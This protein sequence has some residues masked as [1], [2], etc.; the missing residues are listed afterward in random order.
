MSVLTWISSYFIFWLLFLDISP[1]YSSFHVGYFSTMAFTIPDESVLES[2]AQADISIVQNIKLNG[3]NRKNHSVNDEEIRSLAGNIQKGKF[4]REF[5]P[6]LTI[7]PIQS[8]ENLASSQPNPYNGQQF[9]LFEQYGFPLSAYVKFYGIDTN[10]YFGT[11]VALTDDY[12]FVGASGF[13]KLHNIYCS[14]SIQSDLVCSL[15]IFQGQ[16]TVYKSIG[17]FSWQLATK[18]DS[19]VNDITSFGCS[20]A[21]DG[22]TL[23]IGSCSFGKYL[24]SLH[25]HKCYKP[26]V[27]FLD[28]YVGRVY[29]YNWFDETN[30]G[31]NSILE[32]P[33]NRKITGFGYSVAVKGTYLV[34]G[35]GSADHGELV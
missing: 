9:P 31:L 4:S 1:S 29:V 16:V 8:M 25:I 20:I 15:D 23:V 19:P 12:A 32:S 24:I 27:S 28:S 2:F 10:G 26:F 6:D 11:S 33:F 7:I 17:P 5:N 30:F 22:N 14:S 18:I 13:S 21:I 35:A 34:A 3:K